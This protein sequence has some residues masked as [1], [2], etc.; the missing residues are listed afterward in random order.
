MTKSAVAVPVRL[1][2]K[3]AEAL[4]LLEAPP[5]AVL[6]DSDEREHRQSQL[7]SQ[8]DHNTTSFRRVLFHGVCVLVPRFIRRFSIF[9]DGHLNGQ[10]SFVPAY[11]PTHLV[12][13]PGILG[14]FYFYSD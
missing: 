11:G 14:V 8:S 3:A 6:G 5:L 1:L 4:I 13:E 10:R 7:P 2:R 9:F 12:V